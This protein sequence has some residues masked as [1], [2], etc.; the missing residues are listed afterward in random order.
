VE[1]EGTIRSTSPPPVDD[2]DAD[3]P[4]T[5]ELIDLFGDLTP[6]SPRVRTSAPPH[7]PPPSLLTMAS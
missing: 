3:P 5:T 6:H 1:E 4:P 2:E 7:P